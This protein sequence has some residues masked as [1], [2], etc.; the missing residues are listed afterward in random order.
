MFTTI[1]MIVSVQTDLTLI[2]NTMTHDER[3]MHRIQALYRDLLSG[4]G[5]MS[6][7]A[8]VLNAVN[9][10]ILEYEDDDLLMAHYKIKE[11]VF[12]IDN[13]LIS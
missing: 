1:R 12:Y 9:D 5:D 6:Y 13:F 11:A 7:A 8:N 2:K 3:M 10:Y 4:D